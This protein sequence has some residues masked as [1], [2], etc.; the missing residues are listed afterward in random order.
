ME[1]DVKKHVVSP[2]YAQ[3]QKVLGNGQMAGA[4]DGQE[5]CHT[6]DDT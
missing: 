3:V 2:L 6:L 5:F 4:G 1:Q